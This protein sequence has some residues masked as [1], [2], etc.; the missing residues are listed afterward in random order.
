VI[1]REEAGTSQNEVVLCLI[2][3]RGYEGDRR[4]NPLLVAYGPA[5]PSWTNASF[6]MNRRESRRA[7]YGVEVPMWYDELERQMLEHVVD[8]DGVHHIR[9]DKTKVKR[10]SNAEGMRKWVEE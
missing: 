3:P 6:Y 2:W 10:R 4:V 8:T 9:Y 1:D 5:A 7:Q